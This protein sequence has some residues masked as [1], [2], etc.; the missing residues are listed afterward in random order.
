MVDV[1]RAGKR[2]VVGVFALTLALAAC[3]SSAHTSVG[4]SSPATTTASRTAS[5]AAPTTAAPTTTTVDKGKPYDPNK[6]IDLGGTPGVT[7]AEQHRAETL[8]R[9][10]IVGLRKFTTPQEAYAAG[11][12]SI[13]DGVTGDEHY[14]KWSDVDDGHI[15]DP[16]RPESLVYEDRNGTQQVVAAMYMLPFGSRFTDAPDVGGPLTQW[17]VH[18]DLCLSG[19]AEQKTLSGGTSINGQCPSGSTKAGAMPMLHVWVVPNRCGPFAALEGVG[20]GQIP[21]GQTR[22]CDTLHGAPAGS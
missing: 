4:A 15:L 14:I 6:P 20:A 7:P 12:R 3:G 10:T 22:L 21:P 16:T 17:H 8:L 13:G 18:Q 2:G 9:Q 1:T 5:T 11:Y 19:N